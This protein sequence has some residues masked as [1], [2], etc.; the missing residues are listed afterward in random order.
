MNKK[1]ATIGVSIALGG[2]MLLSASYGA[3]ADSSGYNSYKSA[4]KNTLAAK[5]V[6]PKVEISV[7]DNGSQLMNIASTMKINREDRTSSRGT[8]ITA[9][10]QQYSTESYRQSGQA[11]I[12]NSDSDIYKVMQSGPK[13][14][15]DDQGLKENDLN[16]GFASDVE[17]VID[18]LVGNIQNYITQQNNPDGTK[19]VAL[20]L[21]G[22]QIPPVANAAA[23][24]L[25]KNAERENRHGGEIPSG[26]ESKIQQNVPRLVSDIMVTSGDVTANISQ[27]NLIQNQTAHI[28]ISGKDASGNSHEL[29]ISA[30]IDL[31]GF[32]STIP[33]TID[34]TGK[35][36][37][38]VQHE[39]RDR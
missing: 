29:V 33:D 11:V 21:S 28:T 1:L 3:F 14:R 37:Q 35:N 10:G 7:Q 36:V 25:V 23:S 6:T 31:S 13:S 4:L 16:S 20:H 19:D 9:G 8:A 2:I 39:K 15:H 18:A 38:S 30:N 5:S 12:K 32:N 26:L 34:L 17:N 27:D 22:S 24:L